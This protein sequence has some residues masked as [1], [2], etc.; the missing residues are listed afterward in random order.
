MPYGN[1]RNS[2]F[3]DERNWRARRPAN[4][5]KAQLIWDFMRKK[6]KD[7]T[8]QAIIQATNASRRYVNSYLMALARAGYIECTGF[9]GGI[10][11]PRVYAVLVD[12]GNLA[13][14]LKGGS[15]GGRG[16]LG[17]AWMTPTPLESAIAKKK[18]PAN[19]RRRAI[20]KRNRS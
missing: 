13:P 3:F 16:D 10:G 6:K 12:G 20:R 14:Q 8:A 11:R 7:F 2:K 19:N 5:R 15:G 18:T 9:A 17:K 1:D 4:D